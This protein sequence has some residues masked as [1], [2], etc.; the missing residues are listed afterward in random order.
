MEARQVNKPQYRT[1]TYISKYICK[2]I[3]K[4]MSEYI[5]E[6]VGGRER[7]RSTYTSSY[8][9][10]QICRYIGERERK[11]KGKVG[12]RQGRDSENAV[13]VR[14]IIRIIYV[15]VR[16]KSQPYASTHL[17]YYAYSSGNLQ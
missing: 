10:V 7:E 9:S 4:Y 15:T 12:E 11:R 17:V 13:G 1:S 6:Y 16:T 2:Q 14:I 8:I 3:S 5:G